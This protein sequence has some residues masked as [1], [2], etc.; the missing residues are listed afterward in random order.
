MSNLPSNLSSSSSSSFACLYAFRHKVSG[1]SSEDE[2]KELNAMVPPPPPPPTNKVHADGAPPCPSYRKSLRL[3]S[4]QIVRPQNYFFHSKAQLQTVANFFW[5]VIT[6][7][8][9]FF[10]MNNMRKWFRNAN[11][12]SIQTWIHSQKVETCITQLKF[13]LVRILLFGLVGLIK[14]SNG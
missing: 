11:I 10:L 13:S 2:I 14:Q 4:D 8:L 5:I 7:T 12:T 6:F 3:S 9:I 1:W